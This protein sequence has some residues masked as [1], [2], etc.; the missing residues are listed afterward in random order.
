MAK[1][2]TSCD[3]KATSSVGLLFVDR[4]SE[5]GYSFILRLNWATFCRNTGVSDI[6]LAPY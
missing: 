6:Q 1:P 3:A 4:F 5:S 2:P